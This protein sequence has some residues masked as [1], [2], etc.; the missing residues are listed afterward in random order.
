MN[1]LAYTLPRSESLKSHNT[2]QLLFSKG[3]SVFHYPYKLLY[4]VD[5]AH[6]AYPKVLFSASK[7]HFKKALL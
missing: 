6:Q 1:P 5:E 4:L 7:R 3:R 2:I